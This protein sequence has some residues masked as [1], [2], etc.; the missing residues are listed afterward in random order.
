MVSG[1]EYIE[2][3]KKETCA[4]FKKTTSDVDC[5]ILDDLHVLENDPQAR[6]EFSLLLE[7]LLVENH[8]VVVSA[9]VLPRDLKTFD[10]KIVSRL[11]GGLV[12]EIGQPKEMARVDILKKKAGERGLILSDEIAL[13]IAQVVSG[14][15]RE[16]EG[17]LNRLIAYSTIAQFPLDLNTTRLALRDYYRT[18]TAEPVVSS[19]LEELKSDAYQAISEIEGESLAREEFK[20][21]IYVWEMKGFNTTSLKRL[22]DGDIEKLKNTYEVFVK[23]VKRLVELQKE[24]GDSCL[25]KSAEEAMATEPLLFDPEKVAE[26]EEKMQALRKRSALPK[27]AKSFDDYIVGEFN[28]VTHNLALDMTKNLGKKFNPFVIVSPPGC[29]KTHLL[30]ALAGRVVAENHLLKVI[31]CDL[32]DNFPAE[33]A[34]VFALDNFDQLPVARQAEFNRLINQAI[35]DDHQV[36]VT[37]SVPSL[38]I[39]WTKEVSY[40]FEF[41]IDA[42]INNPDRKSAAEYVKRK[43]KE[44]GAEPPEGLSFTEIDAFLEGK[45]EPRVETKAEAAVEVK[46]EPA[47]EAKPEPVMETALE[48]K[49][50]PVIETRV[51][52][53]KKKEEELPV[54][55]GLPGEEPIALGPPAVE[56][57]VKAVS[58]PVSQPIPETIHEPAPIPVKEPVTE[59][60]IS[61]AKEPKFDW[62]TPP[63]VWNEEV[64]EEF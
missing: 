29:G 6:T 51:A 58:E 4:E 3:L 55:L 36:I 10:P 45:Y 18:K 13:E 23:N 59:V 5:F 20:E 19:I 16:L 33:T 63:S 41:G 27:F 1:L 54:P 7:H 49:A 37:S 38:S 61:A 31:Y 52:A 9:N 24:Y 14:S 17:A 40:F 47:V 62:V 21:K 11:E 15:V 50:E 64:W 22:I 30:L 32:K 39:P 46:V 12:C 35:K 56:P 8:Q 25:Q 28:E 34:D 2:E 57:A 43:G 42:P 26:V 53:E 44:A 48:P 60:I